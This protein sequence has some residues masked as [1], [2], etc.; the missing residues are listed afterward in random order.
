MH[1]LAQFISICALGLGVV[2][3]C[4]E[5]GRTGGS[6]GESGGSGGSGGEAGGTGG[7]GGIRDVCDGNICACSEAGIRAAIEA[8]GD[9]PYTFDCDRS[10]PVAT[11]AAIVVDNDVILD[12]EG[13]LTVRGDHNGRV[14]LIR[15]GVTAE[16]RRLTAT[17]GTW[18]GGGIANEGTL[19][20]RD[21]LISENLSERGIGAFSEGGSGIFNAGEMT[22]INSTVAENRFDHSVGGGIYNDC[23]GTLMLLKS[24]VSANGAGV[25]GSAGVGGGVFNAGE[26][27]IIN[28]TVSGNGVSGLGEVSG[29]GILNAGWMSLTNSTISGNRADSGTAIAIASSPSSCTDEHTE[30]SNTLIDGDCDLTERG[31]SVTWVSNGHNIESLG[32]TCGLNH[33]TDQFGVSAEELNLDALADNGG[34]SLTHALLRLPAKSFAIDV[35]PEAACIQPQGGAALAEDQRGVARPQGDKCDVGAFELD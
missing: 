23:S 34:S 16:L 31:P 35:I 28:S 4:S 18:T 9:D 20:I 26:M 7:S 12:G 30:L 1:D 32:N 29:G 27:T 22:I 17:H 8:G 24:T 15:Q 25:D 6:G 19:T 33:E 10:Q 2:L 14:F 13:H 3:G 21:C 11:Q 5:S